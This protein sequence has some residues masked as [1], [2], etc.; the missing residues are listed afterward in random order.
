MD[1]EEAK[2]IVREIRSI[3]RYNLIIKGIEKDMER[4]NQ[5][6]DAVLSPNCPNGKAG[7]KVSSSVKK[8][9]IVNS[10]LS[11]EQAL[12]ERRRDFEVLKLKADQYRIK[13]LSVCEKDEEA[14]AYDFV[15]GIS[16]RRLERIYSFSNAYDHAVRIVKR[17][18]A[19]R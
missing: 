8:E 3:Q 6:I 12:I 15:R 14:F 10:L 7:E 18:N 13:F 17:L 9:T 2:Y 16:F 11:D 19:K 4:I 1:I 5:E